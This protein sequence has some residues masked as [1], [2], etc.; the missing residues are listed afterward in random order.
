MGYITGQVTDA[1]GAAVPA[2]R[3]TVVEAE[4][5]V[6]TSTVT[7]E[8]GF[9][10]AGPL[11]I[12][13][14]EVQ[15]E[16]EGFRRAVSSG[17]S[18]SAQDR[19]RLDV[20]LELGRVTESVTTTAEAPLLETETA[21]ISRVASEQAIRQLPLNGRN[22][23]ALAL[24]SSGTVPALVTR[25]SAGGFNSH[26]QPA[27]ENSFLID[28]IDNNSYGFALEDRKAQV[29]IPS[30]DAVQEFKLQ[31]SRAAQPI[32]CLAAGI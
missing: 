9:Y 11:K 20:R 3:I 22:F 27:V 28:G 26:G 4:T 1:S 13:T 8:A 6:K 25:D 30:L 16:K 31:T 29:V 12:G 18:L 14:Y 17:I 24:L 5:G 7:S 10:T 21:A 32:W 15:V 23:Q 19:R 2:A